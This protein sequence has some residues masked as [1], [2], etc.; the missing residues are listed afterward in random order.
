LLVIGDGFCATAST[1]LP[2]MRLLAT[3]LSSKADLFS[4]PAHPHSP[5]TATIMHSRHIPTPFAAV[6]LDIFHC[7]PALAVRLKSRLRIIFQCGVPLMRPIHPIISLFLSEFD[8]P[9]SCRCLT[10]PNRRR[11][12]TSAFSARCR[13]PGVKCAVQTV[14]VCSSI[15][16]V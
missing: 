6:W 1:H 13:L 15:Q 9:I 3:V 7:I 5:K 14:P 2:P 12:K 4:S 11:I 16:A 10:R 8:L